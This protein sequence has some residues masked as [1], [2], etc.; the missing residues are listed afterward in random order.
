[1]ASSAFLILAILQ[2]FWSA[3]A[4]LGYLKRKCPI[5][6]DCH[7]WTLI[8]SL[9]GIYWYPW[10]DNQTHFAIYYTDMLSMYSTFNLYDYIIACIAHL[11]G[12]YVWGYFFWIF[13]S[14]A[15]FVTTTWSIFLN[16][17]VIKA[18][19]PLFICLLLIVGQRELLD[20]NRNTAAVLYMISGFNIWRS[21]RITSIVLVLIAALLHPSVILIIIGGVVFKLLN[22]NYSKT[23]YFSAIIIAA[24]AS[25]VITKILSIYLPERF[26]E[27]YIEGKWGSGTGVG[28]G[29][30]YLITVINNL[31]F[32]LIGYQIIKRVHIFSR[33]VLFP[34]FV[35]SLIVSISLWFLWTLRERFI[36]CTI[37][38]GIALIITS[39]DE[40][41]EARSS[42]MAFLRC[43]RRVI[44]LCVLRFAL[45]LGQT[46]SSNYIHHT[47]A[48][49][50]DR[51]TRIVE[52]SF[53]L[54]TPLLMDID[55]FGFNDR[56]YL[57][58]YD[59]VTTTIFEI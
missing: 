5:I 54:P 21:K 16:N 10:G 53:I 2:P 11:G 56:E 32:I 31:I 12:N 13:T 3:V 1:M 39:W 40:I 30:A 36:I 55:N 14:M 37:I 58:N 48:N 59:R 20:L 47:G 49:D 17:N 22:L 46:Y 33:N 34:L 15:L 41:S 9:L 26:V 23:F 42:Y 24:I 44:F 45:I 50:P 25:I 51:A 4:Y 19:M 8:I 28:S 43:V 57:S 6:Y 52:N 7:I 29:F 27:M 18:Y 38:L 35:V